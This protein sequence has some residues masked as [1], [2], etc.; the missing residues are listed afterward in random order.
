[1]KN[2]KNRYCGRNHLNT[3]KKILIAKQEARDR[4]IKRREQGRELEQ[5]KQDR[6]DR[7][8][9]IYFDKI[10]KERKA[11]EE[12]K[13]KVREQ[14]ARDRAEKIAA[15]KAE[16]ERQLSTDN[17]VEQRQQSSSR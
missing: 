4:E 11:D 9:K 14:I 10:K 6:I 13:K 16:K 8:N 1:M 17:K 2:E 7:E 12:H 3:K 15:R 5:A